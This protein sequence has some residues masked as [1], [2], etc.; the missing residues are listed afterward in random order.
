MTTVETTL[1]SKQPWMIRH[2]CATSILSATWRCYQWGSEVLLLEAVLGRSGQ[3]VGG[4]SI[5]LKKNDG[6]RPDLQKIEA[7]DRTCS[8]LP[9]ATPP[10]SSS[11]SDPG[12]F[13]SKDRMTIICGGDVKSLQQSR[14][15]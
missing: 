5:R 1:C 11:T 6:F 7:A 10:F 15:T 12:L 13:T 3:L 14:D 9:P 2:A 8:I 4:N